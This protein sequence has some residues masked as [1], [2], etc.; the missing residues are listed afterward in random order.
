MR[1]NPASAATARELLPPG[2]NLL[3]RTY[4]FLLLNAEAIKLLEL[5]L[6]RQ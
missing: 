6:A 4:L 5:E 1:L 3:I 2:P